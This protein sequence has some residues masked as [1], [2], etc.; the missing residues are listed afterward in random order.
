LDG[1]FPGERTGAARRADDG[2]V[3]AMQMLRVGRTPGDGRHPPLL[4]FN[5]IGCNIELLAPLVTRHAGR[6]LATVLELSAGPARHAREFAQR[7]GAAIVLDV[8]AVMPD[9]ALQRAVHDGVAI[10][11]VCAATVDFR[12]AQRLE[13]AVLL[14][15][16]PATCSTTTTRCVTCAAL[17]RTWPRAASACGRCLTW[18]GHVEVLPQPEAGPHRHALEL[19]VH[20]AGDDSLGMP[21]THFAWA[22]LGALHA[23]HSRLGLVE[24]KRF[25]LQ[26][27]GDSTDELGDRRIAAAQCRKRR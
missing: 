14:W 2:H 17:P 9:Y 12:L 1:H 15:A 10:T 6:L 18:P 5:G 27:G 25:A 8:L 23:T 20:L 26:Q 3:F 4:L 7:G 16:R 22:L 13:L 24:D 11:A 19:F 21:A